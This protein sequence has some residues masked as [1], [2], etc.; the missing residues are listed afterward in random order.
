M[1]VRKSAKPDARKAGRY[2]MNSTSHRTIPSAMQRFN[3]AHRIIRDT[4]GHV[5]GS[6]VPLDTD[7]RTPRARMAGANTSGFLVV[8]SGL[9]RKRRREL[10]R[11]AMLP[12][13][14]AN[15]PHVG[16]LDVDD[17]FAVA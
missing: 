5:M 4:A 1:R 11:G 15:R 6:G 12:L 2:V 10:S 3:W 7:T 13:R 8:H 14:G 16:K 9:N 17:A